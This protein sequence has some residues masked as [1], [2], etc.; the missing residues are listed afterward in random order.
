MG[1]RGAAGTGTH[2]TTQTDIPFAPPPPHPT[3]PQPANLFRL[4]PPPPPRPLKSVKWE[5]A[6]EKKRKETHGKMPGNAVHRSWATVGDP[7]LPALCCISHIRCGA[8]EHPP[9]FT[10][11]RMTEY[12]AWRAPAWEGRQGADAAFGS[13]GTSAP[14]PPTKVLPN[15][16]GQAM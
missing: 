10:V 7:K 1:V 6:P 8:G 5:L 13:R 4:Y 14:L 15:G 16:F 3:P 11:L 9:N 2:Q 12:E